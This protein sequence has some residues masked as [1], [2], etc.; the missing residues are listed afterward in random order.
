MEPVRV[1]PSAHE[2]RLVPPQRARAVRALSAGLTLACVLA[3]LGSSSS[4]AGARGAQ[5]LSTGPPAPQLAADLFDVF[6]AAE[7][8]SAHKTLERRRAGDGAGSPKPSEKK[9]VL[10]EFRV[11][12]NAHAGEKLDVEV[13]GGRPE[14]VAV[15]PGATPG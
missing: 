14:E 3:V 7:Q 1:A 4:W 6:T 2:V 11:P 13:R 9:G 5:L 15:P 8:P 10:V 12:E